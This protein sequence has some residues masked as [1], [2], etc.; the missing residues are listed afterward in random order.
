ML[1][2]YSF[3]ESRERV[4]VTYGDNGTKIGLGLSKLER[5]REMDNRWELSTNTG[6]SHDLFY[7][8]YRAFE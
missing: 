7:C 2:V 1:S 3:R 4:F 6:N 5:Q 8:A